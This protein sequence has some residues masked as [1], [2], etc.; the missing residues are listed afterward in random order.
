MSTLGHAGI[1]FAVLGLSTETLTAD[2]IKSARLE[3]VVRDAAGKPISDATVLVNRTTDALPVGG[4]PNT[5]TGPNGEYTLE[6]R[7]RGETPIVVRELWVEAKG[8]VRAQEMKTHP[9]KNGA[10]E[11]IEFQLVTGEVLAGEIRFPPSSTREGSERGTE[12]A[13][14]LEVSGEGFQQYHLTKGS[15]FEIYVPAGVYAIRCLN[16]PGAPWSGLKSGSRE[17]KL[18]PKPV[19]L[20]ERTLGEL[21][22]RVWS[23]IDRNYSYFVVKRDVDWD[24]LKSLYRPQALKAR[25]TG[26]FVS[27]L[28][29]ML[30]HLKDLHV[31]IARSGGIEAC[32]QPPPVERNWSRAATLAALEEEG[33]VDCGFALVGKTKGDGFGY[34][35]MIRQSEANETGVREAEAAIKALREVPGFVVDLRQANGGDERKAEAIAR[36]FC[37]TNT[38][39]ALSKYRNGPAHDA[40]TKNFE[41]T[42]VASPQPYT[43]PVVCLIGPGAVSSGEGF[44]KMMKA[45]PQVTTVGHR[46]RGASG[47]PKPVA[48]PALNLAVYFSRWVDMTPDGQTF[49]GIGLRPD[50][51]VELPAAAH[52][53]HDP[54]LEKGI[55]VLRARV[56]A[57]RNPAGLPHE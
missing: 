35:L 16:H 9:L 50:V 55:E 11:R 38:I 14:V 42:L 17:L 56:A 23:A 31:W 39:Y 46:T 13:Y 45:L 30:A 49:E 1:V 27:V 7:Y 2:D 51:P 53:E 18:E 44:V 12:P 22:D 26:E 37:K 32:Y 25:D 4:L 8:Y 33:R 21:F 54:T 48:L 57:S 19:V 28:K 3:G 43:R 5:K 10:V 15:R 29:A 36:L 41:R 40:F 52:A 20:D 34:F 24:A 6:L 47:N